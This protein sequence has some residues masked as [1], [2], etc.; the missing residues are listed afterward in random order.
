LKPSE[1]QKQHLDSMGAILFK[2]YPNFSRS[3]VY[4]VQSLL[5]IPIVI[6]TIPLSQVPLASRMLGSPWPRL[7]VFFPLL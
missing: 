2:H 5:L 7:R 6:Y 1:C 3:L 4:K